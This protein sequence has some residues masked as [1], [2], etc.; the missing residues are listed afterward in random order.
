MTLSS[1][2]WKVRGSS[3]DHG[4]GYHHSFS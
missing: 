4:I 2:I 3:L 1:Y